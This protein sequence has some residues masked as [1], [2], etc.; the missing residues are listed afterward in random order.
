MKL[1]ATVSRPHGGRQSIEDYLKYGFVP[2]DEQHNAASLTLAYAFDDSAVASVASKLGIRA[3]AATFSKRSQNAY[4]LLW[5]R[6]H[7]L[8]CPRF[9]NGSFSCPSREEARTP[10]PFEHRYTEGDALQWLWFV[11]H[12]PSGLVDLFS[13]NKSFV[14]TLN[15]FIA[16]SRSVKQGGKWK[17]GNALANAWYWA[18]N[19]PD[20]LAPWLFSFAGAQNLTSY[21][22]RWLVS[23]AYTDSPSL[24]YLAMTILVP[25]QAGMCGH[26]WEF[27]LYQEV[28][29][30]LLVHLPQ[31]KL[32]YTDRVTLICPTSPSS[33]QVPQSLRIC[34]SNAY[35]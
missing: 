14:S 13:D 9:K 1:A 20:I 4:K 23:N 26:V 35:K 2:Y 30:F 7:G 32:P 33:L 12:D 11:P 19:E 24:R 34:S 22:I 15:D 28:A 3:D 25:C 27:I 5:S 31:N 16:D 8:L 6:T 29:N 21:W 10:Y 17:Y 18:G